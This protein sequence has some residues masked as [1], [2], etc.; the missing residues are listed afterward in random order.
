[1][2]EFSEK[3]F[4][5][6]TNPDFRTLL[7]RTFVVNN[8]NN[9]VILLFICFSFFI[10][11]LV[12][13]CWIIFLSFLLIYS[14]MKIMYA[15]GWLFSFICFLSEEIITIIEKHIC[16]FLYVTNFPI[17]VIQKSYWVSSS[18]YA[19]YVTHG[20]KHSVLDNGMNTF[21]FLSYVLNS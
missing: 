8:N 21:I 3:R 16:L 17:V 19:H 4:T 5:R 15:V 13:F 14:N 12:C 9:I 6:K 18:F 2:T 11:L 10:C 1:M 7:W 20:Y